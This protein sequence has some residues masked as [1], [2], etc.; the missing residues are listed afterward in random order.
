MNKNSIE[1]IDSKGKFHGYQEWY[2]RNKGLAYR[3]K[4]KIY[5]PIE[6]NEW[7]ILKET[8]YYIE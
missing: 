5:S 8:K 2:S 6:Y 7:H 3:G 1:P 4:R